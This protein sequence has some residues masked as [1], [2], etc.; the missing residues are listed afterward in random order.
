MNQME[1]IQDLEGSAVAYILRNTASQTV[2]SY[3]AAIGR[4]IRVK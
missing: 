4:R 3:I 2:V 1:Y